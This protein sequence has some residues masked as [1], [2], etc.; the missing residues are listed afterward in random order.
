MAKGKKQHNNDNLMAQNKKARHDY[1]ILE[2]VEAGIV[3]TG[4][5][6]K[7]IRDRRI[8]LKD[9]FVQIRNGEAYMM[10]VHISEY[11]QGNQFNHDPLR[12]RKL[13]LHKKQIHRLAEA[14]K[15]KGI[16]IVPLKV[17]LKNGFAKVLIGVAKGKREFDKRETI[18]RRDQKRQIDRVMKHY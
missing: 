8:N 4:T 14:T 7:S 1:S 5:E 16:T 15:D 13:L 3:L 12:N 9:G 2:T 18:K 11:A 6:I 17:Y 10:N